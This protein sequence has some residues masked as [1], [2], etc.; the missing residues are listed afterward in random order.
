MS[1]SRGEGSGILSTT[2][3][4]G[5]IRALALL[6]LAAIFLAGCGDRW[7]LA[8]SR[9]GQALPPIT[10]R[11]WRDWAKIFPDD[12]R[13]DGA[14]SLERALWEAGVPVVLAIEVDGRTYPWVHAYDLCWL[15]QDGRVEIAGSVF[16]GEPL[17]VVGPPPEM[18][19]ATASVID[20]APTIAHALGV[21]A[22]AKSSGR[23]LTA[24]RA[25]HVVYIFLD[26][27]GYL[28]YQEIAGQGVMPFLDSLGSPQLATTLYPSTTRVATA[29]MMTGAMPQVSGVRDRNTRDTQIETLFDVLTEANRSSVSVEGDA[30]AFSMRN[31]DL[32]LSGDRDGNGASDDNTFANAMQVIGEGLPDFLWVHFHGIDDVGH[33]YGPQSDEEVAK[34]AE[35][36]GY[37]A[38]LV[39]ALPADCLLLISADHGMHA[40]DED[41]R[42]GNHGSLMPQDMLVPLWVVEP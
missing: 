7:E 23:V 32:M 29:G 11:Q 42:L 10:A 18:A 25:G 2:R 39:A 13:E 5:R 21:R 9:D 1:V 38:E 28:R 40:V 24:A 6:V 4:S 31:T 33:T 16:A 3:H 30:L 41:E 35:V 27:L 8:L 37:L 34:V 22:P 20:L 12:L 19:Q 14:L 26:G 15:L 36:D 17:A